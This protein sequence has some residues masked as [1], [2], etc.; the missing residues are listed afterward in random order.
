VK[1]VFDGPY[2][3]FVVDAILKG[4]AAMSTYLWINVTSTQ[5]MTCCHFVQ[6]GSTFCFVVVVVVVVGCCIVGESLVKILL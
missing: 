1:T 3:Y 5:K 4:A 2:L 6:R